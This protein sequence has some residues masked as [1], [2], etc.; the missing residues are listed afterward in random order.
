MVRSL[1]LYFASIARLKAWKFQKPIPPI[2]FDL[3]IL[4]QLTHAIFYSSCLCPHQNFLII[5]SISSHNP[6]GIKKQLIVYLGIACTTAFIKI[7]FPPMDNNFSFH[8]SNFLPT[9]S[10]SLVK[11]YVL[12]LPMME[13][14]PKYLLCLVSCIGLSKFNTSRLLSWGVL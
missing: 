7:S 14:S 13:G 6:F 4:S 9:L 8:P 12:D 11:T 3:H 2:D 10:F 5:P 1:H